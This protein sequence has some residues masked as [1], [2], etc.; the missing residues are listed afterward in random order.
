MAV[1]TEMNRYS[2][3]LSIGFLRLAMLLALACVLT[4]PARASDHGAPATDVHGAGAAT[5]DSKLPRTFDLGEFDIRNFRP[6]HNEIANIKFSLHVVLAPTTSE[7][8]LAELENWKRRLRD[9]AI[10][11]VRSANAVDLAEPTLT[12]VQKIMLLRIKRLPLPMKE[13]VVGLYLT[14]FAVGSG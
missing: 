11:A 4:H 13:P 3:C 6:T 5:S 1:I 12:R 8:E 2:S 10:T 14:D 7:V 9:Q